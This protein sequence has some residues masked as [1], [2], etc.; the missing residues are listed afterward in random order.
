LL[1]SLFEEFLADLFND[2]VF[3]NLAENLARILKELAD[4]IFTAFCLLNDFC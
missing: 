1:K 2:G 4:G 3:R